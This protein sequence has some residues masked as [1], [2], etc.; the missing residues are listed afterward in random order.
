MYARK[1]LG[2]HFLKCRWVSETMIKAAELS[3]DDTVLE[4]GPGRGALTR[5][6]AKH[7]KLVM[8]VEKDELLARRLSLEFKSEAVGNVAVIPADILRLKLSDI[9]PGPASYKVVANIPYYLTARI[10][11]LLLDNSPR[12]NL[13]VFTV[14]KE[15]ARRIVARPPRMNLLALSIQALGKPRVIKMVPADCFFPKP[16][17]DSAIIKISAISDRFFKEAGIDKGF[18]F[19]IL[20]RAFSQ[21]RKHLSNSLARL[22]AKKAVLAAVK[23]AGLK[24]GI[25][26]EEM[27]LE[28]WARLAKIIKRSGG[29]RLP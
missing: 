17:V 13:V 16:K 23:K 11:R 29:V 21:K 2:Q 19:E 8:A 26:P 25:R 22:Y 7:A 5:A 28:E 6:L 24:P 27:S 18:F 10:L 3:Q 1:S 20:R 9:L 15:V 12:P 4:I 14:Q